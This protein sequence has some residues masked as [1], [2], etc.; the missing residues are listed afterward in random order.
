MMKYPKTIDTLLYKRIDKSTYHVKN[1]T[2]GVVYEIGIDIISLMNE[3]DG[4]TDPFMINTCLSDFEIE[5]ALDF[6][7]ENELITKEKFRKVR[8]LSYG[9]PLFKVKTTKEMRIASR[10]L[11]F[12][13]MISFVPIFIVGLYAVR[14]KD[15]YSLIDQSDSSYLIGLCVGTALGTI[16]HEGAHAIAGLGYNAHL[17]NCGI[18]VGT[19]PGAFVELDDE[20]LKSSL[21]KAQISAAGIE[22]NLLLCGL[23]MICMR[24][25]VNSAL[26]LSLS[27]GIALINLLLAAVNLLPSIGVDGSQTVNKLIGN[28]LL[29]YSDLLITDKSFLSHSF[30]SNVRGLAEICSCILTLLS[31]IISYPILIIAN[32]LYIWSI[33]R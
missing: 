5:E 7:W 32:I 15:I 3:L 28:D 33:L 12:F 6:L 26:S 2:T 9:V 4:K 8:F 14:D 24:L 20:H 27:G 13:L 21:Q 18:I 16:L 11:N 22:M 31:Q 30:S 17:F 23:S 10:L 29:L 25:L 19:T 1:A